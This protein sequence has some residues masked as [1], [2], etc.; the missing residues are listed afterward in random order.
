MADGGYTYDQYGNKYD[1]DGNKY[2]RDGF[3]SI[4]RWYNGYYDYGDSRRFY[5]EGGNDFHQLDPDDPIA[6]FYK[7]AELLHDSR[8][9][10]CRGKMKQSQEK[11]GKYHDIFQ[12]LVDGKFGGTTYR[13]EAL[14]EHIEQL[15]EQKIREGESSF[16]PTNYEGM[17]RPLK[18]K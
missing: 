5:E 15:V 11:T 16:F 6:A 7:A 12:R 4:D 1:K 18:D 3:R 9:A 17:Y 2:D 13:H 10:G 8:L 14:H